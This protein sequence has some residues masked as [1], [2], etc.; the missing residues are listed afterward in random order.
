MP[1]YGDWQFSIYLDGLTGVRPELPD[2]LR[3]RSSA[4]PRRR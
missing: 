2:V 4:G 1:N 3:R